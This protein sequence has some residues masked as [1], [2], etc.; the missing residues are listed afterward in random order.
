MNYDTPKPNA[1]LN[2]ACNLMGGQSAL[3]A[4]LGIKSPS[5]SE[6]RKRRIP[7]ERCQDIEALT[8]GRVTCHALR[9][10]VFRLPAA[11]TVC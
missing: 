11:Q 6:W 5:I 8:L 10:D 9:P 4:A 7:A 1:A 2:L 3:A